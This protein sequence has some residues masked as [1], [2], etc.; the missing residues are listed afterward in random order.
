MLRIKFNN[1]ISAHN[2]DFK[3]ISSSVVQLTGENLPENTSGF[4]VYRLNDSF[5]GDYSDYKKIVAIKGNSLQL[6]NAE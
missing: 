1:D 2:V 4:K 3:K 6:S 5:L